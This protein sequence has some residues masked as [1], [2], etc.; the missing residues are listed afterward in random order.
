MRSIAAISAP[1]WFAAAILMT[2]ASALGQTQTGLPDVTVTAPAP[3]P[4]PPQQFSPFAGKTRVE[5][6]KWPEIPCG[7]A[8]IA[9]SAGG[10]CQA[11]PQ[12]ETFMS[13][14]EPGKEPGGGSTCSI[15]HQLISVDIGRFAVE[16]DVLI[17]DPYKVTGSAAQSKWCM[18]WSGYKELPND[19][20]D[21]NQVARRGADW[22][23]FVN[24]GGT[25]GT[26][27]TIEFAD[28]RR[29]CLAV[30]RLGPPWRGGF[31]WVLHATICQASGPAIMP[32]DI[33]AVVGALQIR[34]YDPVGNLRPAGG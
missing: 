8:R 30:E 15:G 22:R 20:K 25:N 27:S 16:A 18:V 11:G 28:G 2:P 24:G 9:S 4:A 6:E 12:I 34:T 26:Q 21:M 3:P 10:K 1:A 14:F 32:A 23:N 31:V 33:E 5:E 7:G 13:A 29:G 19:F 17:F